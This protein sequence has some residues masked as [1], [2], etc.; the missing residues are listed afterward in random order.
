MSSFWKENFEM[1]NVYKIIGDCMSYD[2]AHIIVLAG[3]MIKVMGNWDE[4]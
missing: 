3:C 4:T 2:S 1:H